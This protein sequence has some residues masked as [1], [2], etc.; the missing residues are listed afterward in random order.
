MNV[1]LQP[2]VAKA[3]A[4]RNQIDNV[5]AG[6]GRSE[7]VRSIKGEGL[8][9]KRWCATRLGGLFLV[10]IGWPAV[11]WRKYSQCPRRDQI[12]RGQC[13]RGI[14]PRSNTTEDKE[15]SETPLT[16][17]K[18]HGPKSSKSQRLQVSRQGCWLGA[19]SAA[20]GLLGFPYYRAR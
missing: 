1:A 15:E 16:K 6:W 19:S 5:C 17:S 8:M 12:E 18:D 20:D 7:G 10:V 4:A 13:R 2:S 9:L 3:S 11:A 14:S